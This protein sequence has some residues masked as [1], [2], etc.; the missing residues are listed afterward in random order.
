MAKGKIISDENDEII[1]IDF[2]CYKRYFMNYYGGWTFIILSQLSMIFFIVSKLANDYMIGA[3]S[4]Y[5]T[6]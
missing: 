2:N 5:Q 6:S 4:E 3:W 1:K